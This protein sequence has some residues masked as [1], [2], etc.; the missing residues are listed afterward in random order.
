[1]WGVT[2][3][4]WHLARSGGMQVW[5]E[6]RTGRGVNGWHVYTDVCQSPSRLRDG[7]GLTGRESGQ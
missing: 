5:A 6:A 2:A 7:L 3:E 4:S 1:M